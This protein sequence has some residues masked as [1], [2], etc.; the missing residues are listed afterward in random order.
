MSLPSRLD[1]G[2]EPGNNRAL[3]RDSSS[4]RQGE[5]TVADTV[6]RVAEEAADG[7]YIVDHEGQFAFVNRAALDLL[8]Y[9]AES[10]LLGT[11]S[12]ETTHFKRRD[13][14]PFPAD[15]CP[16]LRPRVTG[17][18]VRVD[19]DW[20]VRR[21]GTMIPV[22]YSSAP[23]ATESGIGA[24]VAIRDMTELRRAETELRLLQ[25]ATLL[26]TS[27]EEL[28]G[29]VKALLRAVCE[30]TGW[31]AG[32]MW[33]ADA[34]STRL[35]LSS[36][37]DGPVQTL[38]LGEGLPGR[39]WQTRRPEWVD[40]ESGELK[41]PRGA[42]THVARFAVGVGVPV[43]ADE[44]VVAVLSFFADRRRPDD[45]RWTRSLSA[46]AAQ[47]GPVLL[48]KR[49]ED[50]LAQQAIALARSNADLHSF[51]ELLVHELQQPLHSIV[52]TL[53]RATDETLAAQRPQLLATASGSAK[54][55]QESIDALLRYASVGRPRAEP[56]ETAAIV[57]DALEDLAV[58][59]SDVGAE[60]IRLQLPAVE[61]DRA[62]LRTVLQ[63]LIVNAVRYRS[64]ERLR[65]EVGARRGRGEA[66]LFVRDNGRGIEPAERERIFELFDRG[67]SSTDDEGIGL[68]LAV[69]RHIVEA[70][71][72]RIWVE[73]EPGSGSTFI[74]TLPLAQ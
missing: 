71:G 7:L 51:A 5:T 64:A 9:D 48:R 30:E 1:R 74:F 13:G 33:I 58:E 69:C 45:E 2:R 68:G 18:S 26:V 66:M 67:A 54:R 12:H 14:S 49:A 40:V 65:I 53:S 57:D 28:E 35:E 73:S 61:V 44:D 72:G 41:G 17:E 31:S 16:L 59:L 21:D 42:E 37:D 10:E 39:V 63:N 15:E 3:K 56:V 38:A 25:T 6:L 50:Q 27:S 47:L 43:L 4:Q 29:G 24:V 70:H 62:Q 60:V 8:G 55:L 32:E 22:A 34:T 36:R 19:D 23:F 11:D 20:F 52:R 46:I